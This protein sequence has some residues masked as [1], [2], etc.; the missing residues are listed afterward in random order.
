MTHLDQISEKFI[1]PED[2]SRVV[3]RMRLK[4]KR[5]VFTNGCFDLLHYGHIDYL[6]KAADL[7]DVLLI[8]LNSDASTSKLKGPGRPINNETSRKHI[9]GSLF[10]VTG[11]I[12]FDDPT[13]AALIE[14]IQPDVLVKGGDYKP[15][16][17]VGYDIVTKNGGS[18]VTI[19]FVPG[20]STSALEQKILQS[21]HG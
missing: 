15:E 1:A 11:I 14:T 4:S 7:G 10:F 5:I 18:V 13:P 6:S 16:E 21:S 17:I 19:D 12:L 20:Y 9:L 8:G 3:E 2:I